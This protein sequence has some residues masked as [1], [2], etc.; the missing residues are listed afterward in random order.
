VIVPFRVEV[1][2]GH[3]DTFSIEWPG[4]SAAGP[5]VYGKIIVEGSCTPDHGEDD[6]DCD[7]DG[8]R[9]DHDPDDDNDGHHDGNDDDDDNDGHHD[10]DDD[11]DDNDGIDDR[12]DSK[13]TRQHQRVEAADALAAGVAE[14]ALVADAATLTLSAT[15]AAGDVDPLLPALRVDIYNP[16]GLLVATGTG[17]G[18]VTATTI[19]VL[20]GTYTVRVRNLRA[21]TTIFTTTLVRSTAW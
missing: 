4:H 21:A 5:V 10:N 11:D 18:A 16:L 13:S 1:T 15:G 9:D 17:P 3:P 6:D 19:P 14:F 20:P 8:D 7:D 12:H 2:D